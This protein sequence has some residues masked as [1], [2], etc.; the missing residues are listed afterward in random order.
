M[1]MCCARA[2][3]VITAGLDD[4]HR[5]WMHDCH[6]LYNVVQQLVTPDLS[7]PRYFVHG[8]CD[9]VVHF[10]NS[11]RQVD[12]NHPSSVTDADAVCLDFL[13]EEVHDA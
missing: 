11:L 4:D 1:I 8:S 10:T 6:V 9:G 3:C 7:D 12:Q 2:P 13:I 5:P